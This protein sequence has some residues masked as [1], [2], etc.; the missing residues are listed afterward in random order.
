[1]TSKL[2]KIILSVAACMMM[3]SLIASAHAGR[4]DSN[5]G[6]YNNSTGEY[7]FHHGYPAHSHYD[8]DEDGVIDCPY[9]FDD[10]TNKISN[11][12]NNS[13]NSQSTTNSSSNQTTASS[14]TKQGKKVT[15]FDI[16][17]SLILIIIFSAIAL[18][19]GVVFGWFSIFVA[20]IMV[21]IE[22]LIKWYG[23]YNSSAR[24]IDKCDTV[25]WW[26]VSIAAII[27]IAI[28][29]IKEIGII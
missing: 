27:T 3:L 5:G 17:I 10:K 20:V 2:V 6:H 26:L 12:S 18:F 29:V 16:F 23:C 22:I 25:A 13:N 11:S 4:T 24:T 7:H 21:P 9:N 28:L 14:D 8:M 19:F 1:M 15:F